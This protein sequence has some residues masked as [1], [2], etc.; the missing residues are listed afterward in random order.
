[1]TVDDDATGILSPPNEAPEP[2]IGSTAM[3]ER[4]TDTPSPTCRSPRPFSTPSH[5]RTPPPHDDGQRRGPSRND[6]FRRLSPRGARHEGARPEEDA[7]RWA[8]IAVTTGALLVLIPTASAI[9]QMHA[10]QHVTASRAVRRH[11]RRAWPRADGVPTLVGITDFTTF[12]AA[13]GWAPG[14]MTVPRLPGRPTRAL[15]PRRD[16]R[17]QRSV[18]T[19]PR[20]QRTAGVLRLRHTR[21]PRT[22]RDAGDP[23]RRRLGQR[24]RRHR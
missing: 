1:M 18:V 15:R 11:G 23:P 21:R 7:R 17:G 13:G 24:A 8:A 4:L 22:A 20:L 19:H 12:A 10:T 5:P 16:H 2:R 6:N 3:T 9:A 14:L